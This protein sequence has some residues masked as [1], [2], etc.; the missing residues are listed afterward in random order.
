MDEVVQKKKVKGTYPEGFFCPKGD[1]TEGDNNGHYV[2]DNQDTVWMVV[3]DGGMVQTCDYAGRV[4]SAGL[5]WLEKHHGPLIPIRERVVRTEH[6]R[7]GKDTKK[8]HP[9]CMIDRR[10]EE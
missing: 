1:L 3:R 4:Y 2:I 9:N 8:A 10:E 6:E 5:H 7:N